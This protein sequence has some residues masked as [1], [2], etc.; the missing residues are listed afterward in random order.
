MTGKYARTAQSDA[1]PG[2]AWLV[3]AWSRDLELLSHDV[4]PPEMN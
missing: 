3:T 1:G 4:G 2:S